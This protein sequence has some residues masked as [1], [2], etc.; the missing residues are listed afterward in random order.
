MRE[1]KY[2]GLLPALCRFLQFSI[3]QLDKTGQRQISRQNLK[4]KFLKDKFVV[5]RKAGQ[6]F[7]NDRQSSVRVKAKLY[8]QGFLF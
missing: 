5:D 6:K 2:K 7:D 8:N 4:T 1:N 3:R